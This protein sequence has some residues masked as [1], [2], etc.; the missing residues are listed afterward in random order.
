MTAIVREDQ[1]WFFKGGDEED[2]ARMMDRALNNTEERE[3]KSEA[4]LTSIPLFDGRAVA[5]QFEELYYEM[6]RKRDSGFYVEKALA[7]AK[8][9]EREEA[10][11]NNS[12][13]SSK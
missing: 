12:E 1:G 2:L 13:I 5:K 4:A 7:Y 10:L 3:K 9:I 8:E 11:K 6:L